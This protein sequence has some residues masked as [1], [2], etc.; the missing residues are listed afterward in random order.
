MLG[1]QT[2]VQK[3][4]FQDEGSVPSRPLQEQ[5]QS[6]FGKLELAAHLALG[7]LEPLPQGF[8]LG[9]L[10]K[11]LLVG[12][13]L[14]LRLSGRLQMIRGLS[15]GHGGGF[16]NGAALL[17]LDFPGRGVRVFFGSCD[18]PPPQPSETLFVRRGGFGRFSNNEW[19]KDPSSS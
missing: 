16:R 12:L 11:R 7:R 17:P 10:A 2:T 14:I 3:R 5:I 6:N 18:G 9:E 15:D 13:H 8:C 1:Y 19:V 4:R